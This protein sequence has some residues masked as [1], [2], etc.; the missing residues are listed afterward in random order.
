MR[1]H[2]TPC[3][4]QLNFIC[5]FIVTYVFSYGEDELA[6]KKTTRQRLLETSRVLYWFGVATMFSIYPPFYFGTHN[7]VLAWATF[8]LV[9]LMHIG[10]MV[11]VGCEERSLWAHSYFYYHCMIAGWICT[12]LI[13]GYVWS[14]DQTAI[15]D[16][17]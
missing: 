14:N 1:I 9:L 17:A 12:S 11:H 16:E 4:I 8:I 2:C 13:F 10:C 7:A 15:S 6:R 3:L 5:Q